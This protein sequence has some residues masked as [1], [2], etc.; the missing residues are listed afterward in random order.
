M[1]YLYKYVTFIYIYNL[2]LLYINKLFSLKFLAANWPKRSI[3]GLSEKLI[4][5]LLKKTTTYTKL[6]LHKER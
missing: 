1:S 3:Y 5:V 2:F 4:L 6:Y